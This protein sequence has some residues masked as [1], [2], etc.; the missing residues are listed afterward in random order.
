MKN[1]KLFLTMFLVLG[2]GGA[3]YAH[4]NDITQTKEYKEY[5]EFARQI[6]EQHR[7]SFDIEDVEVN[8]STTDI[9]NLVNKYVPNWKSFNDPSPVNQSTPINNDL[10]IP[11]I[12]I[13]FSMPEKLI[14]E[15]VRE[16]KQYSG[17]L[18]LRGLIDNSLKK[19]V[20]KLRDIEN[21]GDG[22]ES[23]LSIIIHPHL[24]DLYN[25]THVPALVLSRNSMKCVL[26]YDDCL[27]YYDYDKISGGITIKY[28]L[29]QIKEKGSGDI[30]S[31]AEF[32][33]INGGKNDI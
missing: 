18:V 15:Y 17:T 8:Q 22:R 10:D 6:T 33:L 4:T 19:T 24:F 7:K 26:K 12:F 30:G 20:T 13:S 11:L 5:A 14:R 31:I 16:A 32:L 27:S 9:D 29:E 2:L 3:N 21:M 25:I 28:A 1:H 23:N